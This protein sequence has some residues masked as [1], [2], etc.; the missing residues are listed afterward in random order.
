MKEQLLNNLITRISNLNLVDNQVLEQIKMEVILELNNYDVKK[1]TF[2]I[3]P[4]DYIP[5][6]AKVYLT[7]RKI[8]GLK[9]KTLDLYG[10]RIG[11]FFNM[12]RIPIEKVTPND[13]YIW[14]YRLQNESKPNHGGQMSNRTLDGAKTIICTFFKWANTEGYI[15]KNPCANIKPIKYTR[16][17]RESLSEEELEM[18]RNAC[19][20]ARDKAIIEVL[21]STGC[22]VTEFTDIKIKDVDLD[23]GEIL[24]LGK[25]GK[26]R[27]VYLNVK[28]K[29]A[30]VEYLKT[31]NDTL[32]YLFISRQKK[33][34]SKNAIEHIVKNIG[35][36]SGIERRIYPHLFRH[37]T[38]TIGIQR[39]MNVVDVQKILGHKSLDTTMIYAHVAD[40]TVKAHHGN[41][42]I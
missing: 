6:C 29:L 25:G 3:I 15:E 38:A 32:P 30:I 26:Y 39:G 8:E 33:Q 28:A 23:N 10:L 35:V 22:R 14:L 41:C 13:I 16:K 5:E 34:M 42:I 27:R 20:S 17:E 11:Q 37:T 24:V 12:M 40:S 36:K 2:D 9:K 4:Y 7:V 21:Y 31:R 1:R 18:I 19:E